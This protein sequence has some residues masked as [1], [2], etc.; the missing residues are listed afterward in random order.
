M[1]MTGTISKTGGDSYQG[2]R[3]VMHFKNKKRNI[4]N[5]FGE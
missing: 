2:Y 3:D 5:G 4:T 1:T